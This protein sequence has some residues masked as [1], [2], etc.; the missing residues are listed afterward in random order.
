MKVVVS[1]NFD[2]QLPDLLLFNF[3]WRI[4]GMTLDAVRA[5]MSNLEN[6][7]VSMLPCKCSQLTFLDVD[8]IVLVDI[9]D[10]LV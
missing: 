7:F 4:I 3:I 9:T 1:K 10:I 8:F 6:C 2:E 5:V